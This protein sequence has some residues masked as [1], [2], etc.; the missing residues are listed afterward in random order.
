[1]LGRG[2]WKSFTFRELKNNVQIMSMR[3]GASGNSYT[4]RGRGTAAVEIQEEK[5]AT[6]D[7]R[8]RHSM[9]AEETCSAIQTSKSLTC[10]LRLAL[11]K[12]NVYA[13][14]E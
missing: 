14:G 9:N 5:T 4:Q 8:L 12:E 3:S 1:M 10:L 7:N 11:T 6:G 2:N 13:K